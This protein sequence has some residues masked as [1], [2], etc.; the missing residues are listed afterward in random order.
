[1][2]EPLFFGEDLGAGSN[3]LYGDHGGIQLQA[4]VAADTGQQVSQLL[5]FRN[6][7]PPMKVGVGGMN[8][9]VGP[10][11][12][13]WGRPIENLDY[14]RMTGVPETRAI[15]YGILS[16]YMN[17][18]G[19]IDT[20]INL[21]VGLPLEVLS[22]DQ[23]A[24]NA[25][26]VKRWLVGEHDWEADGQHCSIQ[27]S[28]V[29]VTSQP[30]GA[31]FD[32]LLDDEG[33]FI[34]QR[35]AHFNQEMGIISIGFNTLELLTVN[36]RTVVQAMTA[37][38]TLGVRRLLE[39]LNGDNLHTL[40]ELDTKLRS[41]K[42]E[43]RQ[44]IPVWAREVTGQIEKTWGNRWRRFS[45]LIIV[46]GGAI[47]LRELLIERFSGRVHIPDEPVISISRGLYKLAKQQANRR[48]V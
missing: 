26:N 40:G 25:D 19:M 7:K 1:M 2:S 23:A 18:F 32:Y 45:Q 35:R 17:Q 15:V 31:L 29:K 9:Y 47:L 30:S 8:F 20:P 3:K 38:R 24:A 14:E 10:G 41:S 11:A 12:H 42:L 28:E 13:D 39:L 44:A 37:G 48:K 6:R 34:P 5:G 4:V 22:G 27:I 46:G 21:I 16:R 43:I 33:Q 36:D